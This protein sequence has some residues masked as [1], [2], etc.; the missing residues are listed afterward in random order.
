M[1]LTLAELATRLNATLNGDGAILITAVQTLQEAQP[2]SVSFLANPSYRSQLAGTQASAVIVAENMALE[3]PCATLVMANPYYG[4]A[5]VTQLFDNRPKPSGSIHPSA[6]IASSAQ[7]A[8]GVTIAANAVIGEHCIIGANSEIGAGT[9]VGDH[10][11]LGEDCLLHANVTLYHNVVLGDRV[12]IHS[13]S[14]IGADGFGFAPN[15]GK[16]EKIA[17]LGGVVIG[18]NVEIG[19]NTCIDRGALG[20]TVIGNSVILDNLIQIAHNVSIGDGTAIAACTGISGSTKIGKHCTIAGGV[21]MNGHIEITDGVHI[22]GMAMITSSIT[23][24]GA[25]ASGTSYMP[26][27]D[28]RKNVVRFR[29]LDSLAKRIKQLEKDQEG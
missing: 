16:W 26:Y 23:E 17:Q 27:N 29:Q 3:A 8:E 18:N 25:Y 28:W 4:F 15:A 21:G 11:I 19:S 13:G 7:I 2:G 1:Q 9:V 5:Q 10:S 24:P 22:A 12:R 6:V 14:V 20:N